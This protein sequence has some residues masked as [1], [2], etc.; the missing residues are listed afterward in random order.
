MSDWAKRH[1]NEMKLEGKR[2]NRTRA[3]YGVDGPLCLRRIQDI[4]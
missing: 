2:E 4:I 3:L 1:I